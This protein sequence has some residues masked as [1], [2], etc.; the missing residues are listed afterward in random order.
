MFKLTT[1]ICSSADAV[2]IVAAG[3][4]VPASVMGNGGD[5]YV[6]ELTVPKETQH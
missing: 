6:M 4:N 2:Y 3:K 1:L 5:A